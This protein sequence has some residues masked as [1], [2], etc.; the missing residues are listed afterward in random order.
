MALNISKDTVSPGTAS[1]PLTR[2]MLMKASNWASRGAPCSGRGRRWYLPGERSSLSGRHP[3]PFPV[4]RSW[5]RK[6]SPTTDRET[7]AAT[8]GSEGTPAGRRVPV[9]G[10]E[11]K[12]PLVHLLGHMHVVL[13]PDGHSVGLP[14]Q[15]LCVMVHI[16]SVLTQPGKVLDLE[17]GAGVREQ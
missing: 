9:G 2:R 6:P 3:S 16:V 13:T 14:P 12:G 1:A 15:V 7:E 11:E 5:D 17:E 4:H 10:L 8:G